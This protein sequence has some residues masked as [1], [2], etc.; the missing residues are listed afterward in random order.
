MLCITSKRL[1]DYLWQRGCIPAYE[2]PIAAYY[3]ITDDLWMMLEAYYIRFYCIPNKRELQEMEL[4]LF[5][6]GV[7]VGALA[8][9]MYDLCCLATAQKRTEDG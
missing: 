1:I 3:R 9:I 7:C 4:V 8:V 2:T 6:N 5:I